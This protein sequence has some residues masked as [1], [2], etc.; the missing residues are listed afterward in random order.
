MNSISQL[1]TQAPLKTNL[2]K[3]SGNN[4]Q[5]V[6]EPLAPGYGYTL[7]NSLRRIFLSQI[8]GFAVTKIKI[9]D[10][11]HE[12]QPI[13]G[14]VEDALD[15]ILN[16]KQVRCRILN[17]D[18]KIILTL[19][20]T[21]ACDVTAGDF[22]GDKNKFQIVNPELYIC[23]LDKDANLE[24]EVEISRGIGYLPVERVNLVDNINPNN[25][26]VDALFSPVTNVNLEVEDMRVGDM[27]NF[28]R[29]ILNFEIDQTVKAEEIVDFSFELLIELFSK[30]RSS[31]QANNSTTPI[32]KSTTKEPKGEVLDDS[33]ENSGLPTKLV[34]ILNKSG[35][36]TIAELSNRKDEIAD[37][38]GIDEKMISAIETLISEK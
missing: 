11:T 26:L 28:N 17:T 1:T 10:L 2:T 31:F 20:K 36:S 7:G 19:K 6:V 5:L 32:K 29:L 16:I 14:V 4:Y 25:I 3:T 24:I 9:N 13:N 37:L 27:T 34:N 30:I 22:V 38:A 15:V 35:I 21:G 18:D 23:T 8:P 33:L 12:Y